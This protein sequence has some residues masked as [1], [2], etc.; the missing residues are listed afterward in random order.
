MSLQL[1]LANGEVA[2]L[3]SCYAP[4]LAAPLD[5]KEAFYDQLDRLIRAVP[6]GHKLYVLG[7][8]NARVGR[9][10]SLRPKVIGHHGIGNENANGTMLLQTCAIHSLVLTNTVYQQANRFKGTWQHARSGHWHMIDYI[11]TRQADR[12]NVRLTRAIRTTT[13]WSDHRLVKSDVFLNVRPSR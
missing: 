11:I 4:R 6:R 12:R 8:F 10:T 9:D 5:E 2:T 13:L 3:I 7:D 1:N